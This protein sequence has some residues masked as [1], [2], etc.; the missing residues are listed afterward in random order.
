MLLYYIYIFSNK[1]VFL[2][3]LI[4]S[5]V[6]EEALFFQSKVTTIS[7]ENDLLCSSAFHLINAVE[8][9]YKRQQD[10]VLPFVW[11]RLANKY[12]SSVL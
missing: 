1:T 8:M 9:T 4:S 6:V 5:P 11:V 10:K 12:Y 7:I 3:Y 2:A